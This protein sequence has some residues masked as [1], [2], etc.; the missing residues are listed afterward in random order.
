[1]RTASNPAAWAIRLS[2]AAVAVGGAGRA[3]Q[4]DQTSIDVV[5]LNDLRY[6]DY[7]G[8]EGGLYPGGSN[9][10]PDVH[11]DAGIALGNEVEPLAPDGTPA[12]DG[13]VGVV[14]I[15]F[16]IASAVFGRLMIDAAADPDVDPFLRFA[17]AGLAGRYAKDLADRFDPYW[18]IHVPAE[19][20]AAGLTHEQVQVVWL[21]DG[22]Q[23]QREPFP[24]HVYT[25]EDLYVEIA[26]NLRYWFPNAKQ[27]FVS[28]IGYQ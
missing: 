18:T 17:N 20:S 12:S 13:S 14:G 1:M 4:C 7:Q 28:T 8:F 11:R 16:S 21:L 23:R 3:Q 27:C 6:H 25:L 2:F 5:P 9:V 10:C 22:F 24:A 15:G 26:Q 19:L